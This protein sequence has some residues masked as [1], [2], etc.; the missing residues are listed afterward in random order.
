MQLAQQG[1]I[2]FAN[3][4]S[5]HHT[6]STRSNTSHELFSSCLQET[7]ATGDPKLLLQ[8]PFHLFVSLSLFRCRSM[9]ERQSMQN[10]AHSE[11]DAVH[12]W[13]TCQAP[14]P[15]HHRGLLTLRPPSL[16]TSCL[17]LAAVAAHEYH[18]Q[19]CATLGTTHSLLNIT[20]ISCHRC[21]P[22]PK[23]HRHMLVPPYQL[24]FALQRAM[25]RCLIKA[26]SWQTKLGYISLEVS[27]LPQLQAVHMYI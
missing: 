4:T 6:L 7:G 13:A 1:I 17:H 24:R 9:R 2:F 3:P 14:T 19:E 22:S 8:I 25:I 5:Q 11:T 12:I 15:R 10:E 23:R 27:L 18:Q 21:K 26:R 20:P 16:I